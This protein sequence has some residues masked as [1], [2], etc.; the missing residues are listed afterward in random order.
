MAYLL[1]H[2][3]YLMFV[4]I[5]LVALGAI[6]T[7]MIRNR[8]FKK[9]Q[10]IYQK[11]SQQNGLKLAFRNPKNFTLFGEY[12]GFSIRIEP[13]RELSQNPLSSKGVIFQ[14]PLVNPHLKALRIVR[15]NEKY[16]W[17]QG[18]YPIDNPI[19]VNKQLGKDVTIQTNDM[20]F[21]SFILSEDLL[22]DLGVLFTRID[23][24]IIFIHNDMLGC[25]IPQYLYEKDMSTVWQ[26]VIDLLCNMKDELM[27]K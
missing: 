16:P 20:L 13:Y 18:F 15:K 10:E 1:M 2:P 12:R 23:S 8:N 21:S 22:I 25:I 4:F 7:G 11:F 3:T 24:G 26:L 19:Q 5:L 17:I 14:L 27:M 9:K 6:A